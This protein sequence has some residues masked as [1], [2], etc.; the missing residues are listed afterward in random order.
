MR[1]EYIEGKV[2]I[3]DILERVEK[4][5]ML[6]RDMYHGCAIRMPI[7]EQ[8]QWTQRMTDLGLVEEERPL[9]NLF[10]DADGMTP[11][12]KVEQLARWFKK[13]GAE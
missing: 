12:E 3:V 5:E 8:P 6:C 1:N 4:L 13:I 7:N 11:T 10:R 2:S 9:D